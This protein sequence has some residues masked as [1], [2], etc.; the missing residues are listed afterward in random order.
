MADISGSNSAAATMRA[1][2]LCAMDR[3]GAR[4]AG[5]RLLKTG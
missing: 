3:G 1:I 2:D 4:L 5:I